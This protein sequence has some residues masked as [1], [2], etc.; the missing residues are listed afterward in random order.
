[1]AQKLLNQTQ[2]IEDVLKTDRFDIQDK[3]ICL[4]FGQN[5]IYY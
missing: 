2:T 5:R 1:M 3:S 4:K